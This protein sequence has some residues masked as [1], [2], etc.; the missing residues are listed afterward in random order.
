MDKKA[1]E[2]FAVNAVRNS[3]VMSNFLDQFIQDN[4]KEPSWD[5]HVY[6]YTHKS[7]RKD[8][9]KGRLPVQVKGVESND[10]TKREISYPVA[11]SDLTNYL[12]DGGSVFFVVYVGRGGAS[13]QIYYT[14]LTPIKLRLYIASS[15][16]QKTKSIKLKKFP[17]DNNKKETIFFN[18]LENCQKQSSFSSTK[19]YSLEELEK[20]GVLEGITIPV[21]ALGQVD[22]K[23]ALFTNEVY[24]YANIKGSPIPQP[25]E[26]FPENLSIR[27]HR[28]ALVAIGDRVFYNSVDVVLNADTVTTL[29]GDS[30]SIITHRHSKSFNIKYKSSDKL[31]QRTIDSEFMLSYI[32]AGA[33]SY[34][35]ISIPFDRKGANFSDYSV[36]AEENDL[37]YLKKVVQLL[38]LFNCK[39][40]IDLK[41]LTGKDWN[42]I[43]TLITAL[44]DNKDISDLRGDLPPVFTVDIAD[45]KFIVRAQKVK[46]KA[47]TY[48]IFDFFQAEISIIYES[49]DGNKLPISQFALLH[50]SDIVN[51]D[52]LRLDA[53]LPSFQKIER[54]SELMIRANYF[55]LELIKAYDLQNNPEI[56]RTASEF[57]DWIM[58][59]TEAELPYKIRLLN[60]LQ[61]VKRQ[62]SFNS[63]ERKLLYNLIFDPTSPDDIL[64]AAYLLLGEQSLAKDHF[65]KLDK[66]VQQE[67]KT[68]SRQDL[69]ANLFAGSG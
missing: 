24:F 60:K 58:G 48:R 35:R 36:E 13:S 19:L 15:K 53:L 11:T 45:L 9:L 6:I 7:K 18:C 52:N 28:N 39:K 2:T 33:F 26:I 50:A 14:E 44:V 40:D 54:H 29:V 65:E 43:D 59:A 1:I 49:S 12:N 8:C 25:L 30:L 41:S 16:A 63:E 66:Q 42:N 21:L 10:F 47:N 64:T 61:I 46:G 22:P 3:I 4:D 55:L 5:G 57:S 34:D 31:R 69:C 68:W 38:N 27:E 56:I 20:Q 17:E 37:Q 23:L 32:K 67:F 51:A 62:R